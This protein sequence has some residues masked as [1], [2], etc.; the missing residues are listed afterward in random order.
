MTSARR[1]GAGARLPPGG[2]RALTFRFKLYRPGAAAP[3]ADVL[4][5]LEHMG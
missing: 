2:R 4:P 3:L 5:I 1:A